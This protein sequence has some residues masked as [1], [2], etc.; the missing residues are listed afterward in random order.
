MIEGLG[1]AGFRVTRLK[2]ELADIGLNQPVHNTVNADSS[3]VDAAKAIALGAHSVAVGTA[4]I[5]AGGCIACLQ[6][7][8]GQ[9]VVGIATQDPDHEKRYD[10][11]AEA[12]H[13]HTFL[14]S[15]RWQMATITEALGHKDI[16]ELGRDD[17]VALTPEAAEIT[18]LP[19]AP[20]YRETEMSPRKK[21]V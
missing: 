4:A 17:L 18:R 1:D 12:Q 3:G 9:C 15:M 13:I 21:A 2:G 16:H 10:T 20:E 14:E 19:Y 11:N 8:V 5:I 6:C 7:H